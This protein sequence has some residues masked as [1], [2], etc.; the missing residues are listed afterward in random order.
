MTL[1]Y[2]QQFAGAR[3]PHVSVD[4]IVEEIAGCQEVAI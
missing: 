1:E 2:L 4:A 3:I